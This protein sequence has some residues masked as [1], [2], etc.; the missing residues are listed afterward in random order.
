MLKLANETLR[1]RTLITEILMDIDLFDFEDRKHITFM[2]TEL[3]NTN[4]ELMTEA[5]YP[6]R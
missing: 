2:I 4:Q 5:F 3:Y 6:R 1:N